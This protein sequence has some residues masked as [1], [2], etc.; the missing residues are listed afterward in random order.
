MNFKK[1]ILLTFIISLLTIKNTFAMDHTVS[2]KIDIDCIW[3][4]IVN[5]PYRSLSYE[6]F[7][8]NFSKLKP[9]EKFK[10][11]QN[12]AIYQNHSIINTK[13]TLYQFLSLS[14]DQ[15]RQVS[16]ALLKE[17]LINKTIDE[18]HNFILQNATS[19]YANEVFFLN[20]YHMSKQDLEKA[21]NQIL[22]KKIQDGN[23]FK[24][25]NK[26]NKQNGKNRKALLDNN[27]SFS[28]D[29]MH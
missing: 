5:D 25:L 7:T 10:F 26:K 9:E 11:K 29:D 28:A 18:I 27:D 24:K 20:K 21:L 23:A 16:L 1:Y 8:A 12:I 14:A 22:D 2:N 3:K 19:N 13:L 6:E 17:I 4:L 15:K